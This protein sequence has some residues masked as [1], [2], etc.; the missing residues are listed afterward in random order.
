ME[1]TNFDF[2]MKQDNNKQLDNDNKDQGLILGKRIAAAIR[3][4]T[5]KSYIIIGDRDI[6]KSTYALLA[7]HEAFLRL[8]YRAGFDDIER[9]EEH[10][11]STAWWMALS[12]IKFQI[13]EITKYL[14]EGTELY[15]ATATK[16]PAICWDDIRRHGSGLLYFTN[17][18]LYSEISGLLDTIKIPI[19]VFLGTSP[20]M[21]GVM[22]V[23]KN[24]DGYQINIGYSK[25]GFRYRKSKCY[26]WKTSPM[27]QRSL[28]PKFNDT[29]NCW[30]PTKVW[31]KY[32]KQRIFASEQSIDA[33]EQADRKKTRK[34]KET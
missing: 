30:L 29:F 15:K 32:E 7:L 21:Q 20:S 9:E 16:K 13:P 18:E 33:V 19:N 28:Y 8:N 27:G 17:K 26:L 2:G 34:T 22:Q 1:K 31:R 23:L 6:G 24:Y 3:G 12:C 5:F 25:L 14:K 4:N 11:D 10:Q